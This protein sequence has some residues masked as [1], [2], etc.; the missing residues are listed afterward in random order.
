MHETLACIESGRLEIGSLKLAVEQR[1][2]NLDAMRQTMNA[3]SEQVETFQQ[4]LM[5]E[6]E[7]SENYKQVKKQTIKFW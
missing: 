3:K 2:A 4:L 5:V 1:D 7:A 6:K